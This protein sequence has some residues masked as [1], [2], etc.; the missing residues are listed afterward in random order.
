MWNWLRRLFTKEQP[1]VLGTNWHEGMEK[2]EKKHRITV[3]QPARR[4][5]TAAAIPPAPP[6]PEFQPRSEAPMT[7]PFSPFAWPVGSAITPAPDP[8]PRC[9]EAYPAPSDNYSSSSPSCDGGSSSSSGGDSGGGGS[10][11]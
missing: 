6:G 2:E 9:A 4:H 11:D 10:F 5:H 1:I 8:T 7:D 3:V